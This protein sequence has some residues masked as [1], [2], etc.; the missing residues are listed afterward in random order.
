MEPKIL[1][2][3]SWFQKLYQ[4][5][6]FSKKILEPFQQNIPEIWKEFGVWK[7]KK[8]KQTQ[9]KNENKHFCHPFRKYFLDRPLK[10]VESPLDVISFTGLTIFLKE[11]TH[12]KQLSS[13]IFHSFQKSHIKQM[14]KKEKKSGTRTK[15][16][17]GNKKVQ[18]THVKHFNILA[19]AVPNIELPYQNWLQSRS[20]SLSL[21]AEL[22]RIKKTEI[23]PQIN[24]MHLQTSAF[25]LKY[26][27]RG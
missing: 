21:F 14:E 24:V 11:K 6:L 26:Y 1:R 5:Y 17:A 12:W 7:R 18:T 20:A 10:R 27:S 22:E 4:K 15:K 25:C 3:N 16:K 9:E 23:V 13:P 19:H 8:R 2:K